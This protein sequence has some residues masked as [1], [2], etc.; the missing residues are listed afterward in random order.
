M[1]TQNEQIRVKR[2]AEYLEKS[3]SKNQKDKEYKSEEENKGREQVE[4]ED[5]LDT[6]QF[7]EE[8]NEKV[9]GQMEDILD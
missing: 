4:K 2:N 7:G 1:N 5:G 9:D 8:V 6:P 3:H